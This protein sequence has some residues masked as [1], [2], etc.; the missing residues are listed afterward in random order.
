MKIRRAAQPDTVAL[1]EVVRA[2][3]QALEAAKIKVPTI[4]QQWARQQTGADN[5]TD[6]NRA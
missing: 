1:E 4:A 5:K 2:L 6:N 3:I